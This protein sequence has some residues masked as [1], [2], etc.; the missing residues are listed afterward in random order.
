VDFKA[1]Q[2][3]IGTD[4]LVFIRI[5]CSRSFQ[6]LNVTF[7]EYLR[8]CGTD[9]EVAIKKEMSG[10]FEKSLL[11]IAKVVRNKPRYYAEMMHEAMKGLGTKDNDLI[12]LIVS[13][14]EIDLVQIK[15]EYKTMFK[16]SLYDAV[17]GELSGDYRKL[18]LTLIGE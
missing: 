6:Q 4:E 18:F 14:H 9:I 12:R 16:K 13:R 5:F 17:K 15:A 2:G 11:A 7:E 8:N 1:G 3:K 10:K